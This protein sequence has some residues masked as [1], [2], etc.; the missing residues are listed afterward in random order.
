MPIYIAVLPDG[1]EYSEEWTKDHRPISDRSRSQCEDAVRRF[2]L[3]TS[4]KNPQRIEVKLFKMEVKDGE[5]KRVP[6]GSFDVLPYLEPMTYTEFDDELNEELEKIPAEFH[7]FVRSFSN[8]HSSE[9]TYESQYN[10]AQQIVDG[11]IPCIKAL[12]KKHILTK[13]K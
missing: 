11:L 10:L 12:I 6:Q 3:T 8:E 4:R 7:D 5:V 1:T 9:S 2:K 13:R